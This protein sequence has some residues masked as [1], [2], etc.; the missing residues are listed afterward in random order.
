MYTTVCHDVARPSRLDR[1]VQI[2]RVAVLGL[3][4]MGRPIARRLARVD[5]LE[6]ALFDVERGRAEALRDVGRVAGSAAE[7]ASSAD[8]VLTV[9]PADPHVRAVA[10]EVADS[11]RV[12]QVLVE[13]STIAPATMEAVAT[14]LADVGVDTIA[15]SITRG[16]AAAERGEL[17]LFVS[18]DEPFLRPLLEAIASELRVVDGVGAVKAVKI[19]NNLVVACIDIAICEGLVLGGLLGCGPDE[20]VDGLRAAGAD[21]WCLENHIAAFVL[22]DDLGPGHFST[23][24][25]AKDVELYLALAEE[26][27][28]VSSLAGVAA[29]CYRGTIAAG[30]GEHYHPVVVRWLER[31]AGAGTRS[32]SPSPARA[33]GAVVATIARGVAAAQTVATL[34]ALT[35]LGRAGLEPG[36]A[37]EH[38]RSGSA[39][40]ASLDAVAAYLAGSGAAHDSAAD[41]AALEAVRNLAREADAPLL[42]LE[43]ART[44]A[45]R[46]AART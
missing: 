15:V 7:A 20:V 9:L 4:A 46:A 14:R 32:P 6:L 8:V 12:G 29:S 23:L 11:A 41:A 3:G 39:G 17:A 1:E 45:A 10:D 2:V 22:P 27:G 18:R 19:A 35:V 21:S 44:E 36:L 16:V 26:T 40:N 37:V 24:N 5:G 43:A 42:L 30:L 31:V 13:L 38:L 28:V 33:P 34:E 25:M